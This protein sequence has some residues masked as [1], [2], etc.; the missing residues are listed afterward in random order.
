MGFHLLIF[1]GFS[2]TVHMCPI[3]EEIEDN[4]FGV[5]APKTILGPHS[6][7]PYFFRLNKIKNDNRHSEERS[8]W[9]LMSRRCGKRR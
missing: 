6:W 7:G 9:I 4:L 2:F 3:D 8:L 5:S 1:K